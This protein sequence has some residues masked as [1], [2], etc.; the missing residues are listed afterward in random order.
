MLELI[1][2]SGYLDAFG[3]L[4]D[5]L[6]ATGISFNGWTLRL[7]KQGEKAH[8]TIN[9]RQYMV[10]LIRAIGVTDA[11]QSE[12]E[13]IVTEFSFERRRGK[14]R[15]DLRG[16]L[17]A[18]P[19]ADFKDLL[20]ELIVNELSRDPKFASRIGKMIDGDERAEIVARPELR[21]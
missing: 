5:Q 11:Q 20:I 1:A 18:L 17:R 21:R 15:A 13:Q 10:E 4:N 6:K 2:G 12:L 7:A 8:L 14:P 9:D 16:A 19:D 3:Q